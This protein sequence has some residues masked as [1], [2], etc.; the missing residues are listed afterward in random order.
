M[1]KE[2]ERTIIIGGGSTKILGNELLV[3][4]K[5]CGKKTTLTKENIKRHKQKGV[6]VYCNP[7]GRKILENT[8]EPKIVRLPSQ[9]AIDRRFEEILLKKFISEFIKKTIYC[10]K[11]KSELGHDTLQG[12]L[13]NTRKVG[14][15]DPSKSVELKDLGIKIQ[16]AKGF[17]KE[18]LEEKPSNRMVT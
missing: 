8:N 11:C 18:F 7:C 9:S 16:K 12:L 6:E 13:L 17:P 15:K 3:K 5:K 10:K 2:K 1:A 14:Y 4:C